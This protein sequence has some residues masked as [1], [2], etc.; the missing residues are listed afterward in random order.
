MNK[1]IINCKQCTKRC[2]KYIKKGDKM[3]QYCNNACYY[4]MLRSYSK[5]NRLA[6]VGPNPRIFAVA[7]IIIVILMSIVGLLVY[8]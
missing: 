7:M 6:L 3:P 5:K 8:C 4:A 2:V 1:A